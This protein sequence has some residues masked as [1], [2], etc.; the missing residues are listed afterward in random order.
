MDQL[1]EET[2]EDSYEEQGSKLGVVAQMLNAMRPRERI[3][4]ASYS[5]KVLDLLGGLC[6]QAGHFYCR[7]D[8]ATPIAHRQSI[9]DSF[10]KGCGKETVMLLSAKAGGTGLNLVGASRMLLYDMDWNPAHDVQGTAVV[11]LKNCLP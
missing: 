7:L 1:A 4:L 5:T 9:V 6:D 8:G 11:I 2:G 10:N 3:V